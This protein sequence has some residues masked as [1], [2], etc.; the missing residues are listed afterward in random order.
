MVKIKIKSR[1]MQKGA[2]KTT[3]IWLALG[4]FFCVAIFIATGWIQPLVASAANL[5]FGQGGVGYETPLESAMKCSVIRCFNGCDSLE[6][7]ALSWG[8]SYNCKEDFCDNKLSSFME[9]AEKRICGW[10]SAQY[11]VEVDVKQRE[12]YEKSSLA[13]GVFDCVFTTDVGAA[14]QGF[15]QVFSFAVFEKNAVQVGTTEGCAGADGLKEFTV[16]PNHLN[17]WTEMTDSNGYL[18]NAFIIILTLPQSL[19][20]VA[21]PKIAFWTAVNTNF[22]Y[23]LLTPDYVHFP[24]P[25][26]FSDINPQYNRY[27]VK[28]EGVGDYTMIFSASE[29]TF[30]GKTEASVVL[31]NNTDNT[32]SDSTVFVEEDEGSYKVLLKNFKFGLNKFGVECVGSR[33]TRRCNGTLTFNISYSS[34]VLPTSLVC[35]SECHCWKP[36]EYK[37]TCSHMGGG[38][39]NDYYECRCTS[40][41]TNEGDICSSK[42]GASTVPCIPE[43]TWYKGTG[44]PVGNKWNALSCNPDDYTDENACKSRCKAE[45][46]V[47]S[48]YDA[49][50]KVC[51][52]I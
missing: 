44:C 39:G 37:T 12:D 47:D 51:T 48:N 24:R 7:E 45:G 40:G 26:T 20:L 18:P 2:E 19:V 28:V 23:T 41:C 25:Y 30:Q 35:C 31:F 34:T 14:G 3:I 22:W 50:N 10:N 43:A 9:G 27:R 32:Q 8:D 1:M 11:A 21:W 33:D 6:A 5:L 4:I 38:Y 17:I 36:D 16:Q 49:T 13:G 29:E 52:C 46:Y 15:K 42:E